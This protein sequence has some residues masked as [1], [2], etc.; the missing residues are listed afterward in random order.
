MLLF[1]PYA[2]I[3]QVPVNLVYDAIR[4]LMFRWGF[5]GAFRVDNG[6][7]LGEPTR[8]AFSPLYLCLRALGIHVKLNPARSPRKNAKVERNQG[9][10]ARWA[11]P[12]QCE[13][14]LHLQEKLNQAVID[15]RENYPTRVCNF[16]TRAQ[17]FPRLFDNPKR[18]HPQDFD[19][20]RVFK[21]LGQGSWERKVSPHGKSMLF[22]KNYQVGYRNR[23]QTFTVTF[24]PSNQN[25]VF[26]DS[27]ATTIC[28]LRATNL[29]QDNICNLS[30]GQ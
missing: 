27:R 29:T 19:I 13:N 26:K 14:Y 10:T 30:F 5:I 9:T 6:A 3:N 7:P 22:G 24:D 1:S 2:R 15:Q 18:F 17:Q 16:K 28:A 12:A 20:Q 25:W 21:F 8:Q 11:E 4:Y 23:H